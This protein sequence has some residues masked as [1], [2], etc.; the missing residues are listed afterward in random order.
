MEKLVSTTNASPRKTTCI[1]EAG[2]EDKQKEEIQENLKSIFVIV[3][4]F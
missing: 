1:K 2:E 3:F 4:E